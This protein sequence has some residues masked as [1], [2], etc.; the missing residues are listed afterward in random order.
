MIQCP[1]IMELE[2]YLSGELEDDSSRLLEEHISSCRQ[3]RGRISEIEENLR[4][5]APVRSAL[6]ESDVTLPQSIGRYEIVRELGRGGMG[7]V[8]EAQQEHPKRAVA[9]KVIR[10]GKFVDEHRIKLFEREVQML[11]RLKHSHIA[12]I[13]EAGRTEGGQHFFAMELVRGAPLMDYARTQQLPMRTRLELFD[14]ICRAINY[15]HQRGVIHRDLKPSNILID[16]E[17]NPKILDF[18]LAKMT[19]S[20][21]AVTTVTV[22]IGK[23]QG[24]LP[25]MSPEQARGNPDQ[26]DLRSDVYSLGVML[27]ELMTEQLPYDVSS[28]RGL[29]EAVR[30][31]CEEAPRRPST[32]SKTLRGDVETIA[33]KALEKE[34]SRRYQSASAFADDVERYLT[35]QPILARPP[36]AMYQ[37][38]KFAGRNKALVGAVAAVFVVLVAGIITTSWQAVVA[39]QARTKAEEEKALAEAVYEFMHHT[40]TAFEPGRHEVT[41]REVL[42]GAAKTIDSEFS[43]QPLVE[44][45]VRSMIQ[46]MYVK[47][48]EYDLAELHA[49]EMLAI[50][51]RELGD[52]DPKTLVAMHW[53]ILVF[54]HQ[55]RPAEAVPLAREMVAI[56]QREL[57]EEDPQ[58]LGAMN[59][60][61]RV[62]QLEGE[63][64]ESERLYRQILDSRLRLLG[65]EHD[66]T[67]MAMNNLGLLLQE[68][69]RADEA[70]PLARRAVEGSRRIFGDEHE[71]TL[72][73]MNNLA[74]VFTRQGKL[75]EAGPLYER[76]LGIV[77]RTLGN[78]HPHTIATINNLGRHYLNMGKPAEAEPLFR[79]AVDTG[80][81]LQGEQ[82]PQTLTFIYGLAT[83]LQ[84]MGRFDEAEKL[85]RQV[86]DTYRSRLGNEHPNTLHTMNNYAG[87]LA[88]LDRPDEAEEVYQQVLEGRSR[89][90]GEEHPDT[91]I[92]MVHLAKLYHNQG[93]NE[94]AEPLFRQVLESDRRKFG[95]E[96][97]DTIGSMVKLASALRDMGKLDQAEP[98]YSE[99]IETAERVLP[100]DDRST[101]RYHSEYGVCL[102]KLE[103]YEEAEE[104][105]LAGSEGIEKAQGKEHK[106][107]R[108]A[109]QRLVE[110]Y[111]AWDAAEPGKGHAEVAAEWR[112]KLPAP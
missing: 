72:G 70:E 25:Y 76:V 46:A 16:A 84:K 19:D 51:R 93:R 98:L 11:G 29:P 97:S 35:N 106:Q 65:E 6:A 32:I 60:L 55:G 5:V 53:L 13:Y 112:A 83:A 107:T 18:G 34:P 105:L 96:H 102:T 69:G 49:R 38:R 59:V 2:H 17:G 1:D 42:D 68:D 109:R 77:R 92:S 61:A 9:L 33:L 10:G 81:R 30:V 101:P 7:A 79:E 3:R 57:G 104:Q 95:E 22:E 39:D 75:S 40:L 37:L 66:L 100:A 73:A 111:E 43:D 56:R 89:V 110:L 26:I 94:E 87:L 12:A 20:D 58:T 78:E 36:S 71:R 67:L 48:G 90:L 4:A 85:F 21:V 82:H 41:L 99:A 52:Q 47:L 23:I 8:Y 50:R 31:I 27:Y 91:L 63:H 54:Q 64:T 88:D 108:K 15:A 80:R 45:E 28:P 74:L 62:F 103:R 86:L 24:T 14:K 44:A